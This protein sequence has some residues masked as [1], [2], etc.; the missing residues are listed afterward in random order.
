MKLFVQT[1]PNAK[2][3]RVVEVDPTHFR[4][5]VKA[6]PNEGRANKAVLEAL[7]GHLDLP[8][9]CLTLVSGHRSKEKVVEVT[10]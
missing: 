9:S 8:K 6:S 5:W 10:A 3:V 2:Q 7:S 1:K 4:V